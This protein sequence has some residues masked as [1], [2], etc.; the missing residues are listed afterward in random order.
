MKQFYKPIMI[1][2][3]VPLIVVFL[4]YKLNAPL[5]RIDQSFTRDFNTELKLRDTLSIKNAF[6]FGFFP[7]NDEL[8][9]TDLNNKTI[10]KLKD[11]KITSVFTDK[12]F[13][14]IV[15][16]RNTKNGLSIVDQKSSKFFFLSEDKKLELKYPLPAFS[17][18][19]PIVE[20]R[21]LIKALDFKSKVR[22]F[23]IFN[24]GKL[25]TIKS[26]LPDLKDG[27][28]GTDGFLMSNSNG[29]VVHARYYSSE[30]DV[31]ID[32]V[33]KYSFKTIDSLSNT[34][35]KVSD[36][37][38]HFTAPGNTI[39]LNME[40]VV[41]D[42]ILYLVS[43]N[44]GV[45]EE[46]ESLYNYTPIDRYQIT[47]GKYLGSIKVKNYG[48]ERLSY[49]TIRDNVMWCIFGQNKIVSYNLLKIN[50]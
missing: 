38:H 3:A 1:A 37:N 11:K 2:T 46:K 19:A 49:F 41:L 42:S 8:L 10:L 14:L 20:D 28:I 4:M 24:N 43:N 31:F 27:G 13:G 44:K 50:K 12:N 30:I 40:G 25:K 45:G 23:L 32:S 16:A 6:L 34:I 48:K 26:P 21:Y 9:L 17:R 18:I 5:Y 39:L 35:P 15:Y 7:E 33:F 22:K 29:V 47:D 36:D